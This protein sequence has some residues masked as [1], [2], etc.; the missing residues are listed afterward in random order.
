MS[1]EDNKPGKISMLPE[2][3]VKLSE[4]GVEVL[5]KGMYVG[6]GNEEELVF[7]TVSL[8]QLMQGYGSQMALTPEKIDELAKNPKAKFAVYAN[9]MTEKLEACLYLADGIIPAVVAPYLRGGVIKMKRD[10]LAE[11]LS[12]AKM[13]E[14]TGADQTEFFGVW[15]YGT[16]KSVYGKEELARKEFEKLPSAKYKIS[17]QQ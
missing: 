3:F 1:F 12:D 16:L 4:R 8:S 2:G 10:E 13:K 9:P 6:E 11:F 17:F 5:G 14:F 7:K 15:E